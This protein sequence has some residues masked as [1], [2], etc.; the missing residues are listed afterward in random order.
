[1]EN[2]SKEQFLELIR[3]ALWCAEPDV[4]LFEE[5]VDW[6]EILRL[7]KEQTLQGL[8]SAAI[9]RLPLTLRPSRTQGL[10]LHQT[11]ALNR[12]RRGHQVAVLEKLLEIVKRAGVERPVLLKG[13]GVGMNYPDP[14]LRMCGDIDLYVG[15]KHYQRVWDFICSEL[16]IEKEKSHSDHHFD[17]ELM[18]TPIEIHRYATSPMSIASHRGEFMAWSETQLEGTHVRE[19]EIDGVKVCLPSYNFDFIYIFYHTWKHFLTCGVGLRQLCDWSCYVSA[20]ADRIDREELK[21]LI[22]MFKL[23]TPISLFATICVRELGVSAEKFGDLVSTDERRYSRALE[24][25]WS[26]GNFGYYSK[27][28]GAKS[29]TIF[30]QKWRSFRAQLDGMAFMASIDCIYTI[31]FYSSFFSMRIAAVLRHYKSLGNKL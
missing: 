6:A 13:L 15:E 11:V 4:A 29:R 26:D 17:F 31:K 9:E 23:Y 30:Q 1:M 19:V 25:I 5:G 28:R 10:R 8:I 16:G 27:I 24:K 22:D 18:G 20:F 7:A 21:Q 2:R 14:T 12:Q 3:S